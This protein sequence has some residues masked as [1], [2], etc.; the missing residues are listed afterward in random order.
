MCLESLPEDLRQTVREDN[1]SFEKELASWNSNSKLQE[2]VDLATLD[3][4]GGAKY[5][6][7]NAS[8][9]VAER[10]RSS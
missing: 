7:R 5:S 4:G 3:E 9:A 8:F 1:E 10:G 2:S 6:T